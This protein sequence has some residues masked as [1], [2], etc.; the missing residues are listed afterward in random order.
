MKIELENPFIL[1]E[2]I[3]KM[4]L[5]QNVVYAFCSKNCSA[6]FHAINKGIASRNLK[7]STV[8]Q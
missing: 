6:R 4:R 7:S 1:I 2:R 3:K 8:N 5:A